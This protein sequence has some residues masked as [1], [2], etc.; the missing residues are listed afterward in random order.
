MMPFESTQYTQE[1]AALADQQAGFSSQMSQYQ[2][3]LDAQAAAEY[4]RRL[5]ESIT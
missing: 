1:R 2:A 3:L 5:A 4:N